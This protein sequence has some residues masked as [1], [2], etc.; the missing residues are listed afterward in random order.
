MIFVIKAVFAIAI[1]TVLFGL[2]HLDFGD[3]GTVEFIE[4]DHKTLVVYG[5]PLGGRAS[6]PDLEKLIRESWPTADMLVP[7]Y[8]HE[9]ASNIDPY[10]LTSMIESSIRTAYDKH[11]YE[12]IILFGYSTGGLLLRKAYLWGHGLEDRPDAR[13]RGG[14]PWVD[15]VDRFVSLAAPNRGWPDH[16]PKNLNG[17]LYAIGYTAKQVGYLTGTGQFIASLMQGSPFVANMRVHW[18]DLFRTWESSHSRRLPL[19]IHLLGEKDELVDRED[20]IDF[21]VVAPG[22]VIIKT[23]EGL[24]H[25]EIAA[26]LYREDGR[27]LSPAGEAIKMSLTRAREEF[28]PYWADKL[29]R[30]QTDPAVTQLIFVMH[31]IR[32]ESTWPAEVKRSIEKQIGD[33]AATVKVIPPLYRRF[34]MLPFLLYW[35]RQENVRWFMDQYIQARAMYPNVDT[36]D[37]IGHSNGTYI[38]A[39]A[40]QRYPVLKVRNVFFAGSVVPAHYDWATLM[41]GERVTGR[42]WNICADKDWVVAIFPQFFQQISDLMKLKAEP[43]FFDIGSA[44]FRGFRHGSGDEG[45]LLNLKYISGGHGAAVKI[46]MVEPIATYVAADPNLDFVQLWRP[47]DR[48]EPSALEFASNLSWLIWILGVSVIVAAGFLMYQFGRW[49]LLAYAVLMLGVLMTV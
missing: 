43:G 8:T 30:L 1:L 13:A 49:W 42:V 47:G 6:R 29:G 27:T 34:A 33:R 21:E 23:L 40:L 18:I 48:P 28:P 2:R 4:G 14:H 38:L 41:S 9:W 35:D 37:F 24:S 19:I 25:A 32:D 17:Y 39:S 46:A 3:A 7:T 16:K 22:N 15:S 20:S 44:G 36:M 5:P 10:H 45:R 31:G 12:K 26:L 11:S